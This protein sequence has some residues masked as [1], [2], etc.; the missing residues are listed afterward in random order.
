V[1]RSHIIENP[2]VADLHML[3]YANDQFDDVVLDM[4]LGYAQHSRPVR[5]VSN[6]F[7]SSFTVR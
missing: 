2:H 1:T 4:M 3:T 7:D 5:R 6:S